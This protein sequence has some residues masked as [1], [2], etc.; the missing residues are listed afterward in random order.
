ME[1]ME[2][3]GKS[4]PRFQYEMDVRPC[5]CVPS[6]TTEPGANRKDRS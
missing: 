3:A 5:K 4:S 2:E 6:S 1:V